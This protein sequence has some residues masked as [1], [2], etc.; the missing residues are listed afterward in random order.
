MRRSTVTTTCSTASSRLKGIAPQFVVPDVVRAAEHY[1]DALGF[2][3][4]DYFGDPPVF[5]IV[6][7]DGVEIHLGK[8]DTSSIVPNRTVRGDG[9]DAY[10]WVEDLD[11]LAQEFRARGA[12]ILEGPVFRS[13]GMRE[14]IVEDDSCYRLAFAE[15]SAP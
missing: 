10:I 14:L 13:Y 4:A 8:R 2:T 1:R 3:I 11:T 15:S 6:S 12:R 9:L 5:A 7:R